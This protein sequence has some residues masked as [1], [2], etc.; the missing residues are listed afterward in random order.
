MIRCENGPLADALRGLSLPAGTLVFVSNPQISDD[1]EAVAGELSEAFDLSQAA[2][3]DGAPVVYIVANDDLLGRE[4]TGG[5]M[6]ACGLL[7]AA[8]T[9]AIETARSGI[10]ANTIAVDDT[11]PEVVGLWVEALCRPNAPTGEILRL[12]SGHLGKALP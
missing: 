4:G 3:R 5:A 9:L 11:S 1:W 6:V 7:S 10:A 12:G 2:A 8:R